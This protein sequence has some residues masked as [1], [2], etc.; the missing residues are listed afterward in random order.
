MGLFVIFK[1][2]HTTAT[3]L[4][5]AALLILIVA[6]LLAVC[7][8]LRKYC[9]CAYD[10]HYSL[11]YGKVPKGA[12]LVPTEDQ[13]EAGEVSKRSTLAIGKLQN[14]A[15]LRCILKANLHISRF[16]HRQLTT[17]HIIPPS[18]T[19]SSK[20]QSTIPTLEFDSSR[21]RTA[22]ID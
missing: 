3:A 13:M 10:L 22:S 6:G 11:N 12:V 5:V 18:D 4:V 14:P 9:R 16:W 17:S 1:M 19:T 21:S 20:A 15:F 8:L 2:H 7:F